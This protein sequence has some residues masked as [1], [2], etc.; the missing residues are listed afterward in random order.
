MGKRSEYFGIA[1]R[2]I[3]TSLGDAGRD[4]VK[5][6]AGEGRFRRV[7]HISTQLARAFGQRNRKYFQ[8]ISVHGI[9]NGISLLENYNNMKINVKN[10]LFTIEWEQGYL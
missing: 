5:Q 8:E 2:K 1:V 10:S 4:T 7:G 9:F 6:A 3:E